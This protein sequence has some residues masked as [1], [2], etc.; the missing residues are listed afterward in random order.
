MDSNQRLLTIEQLANELQ[1]SRWT[2]Y[3]WVSQKKIPFIKLGNKLL[4]FRIDEVLT[5][6]EKKKE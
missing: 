5:A 6:L 2:V 4:R 3:L 1:I